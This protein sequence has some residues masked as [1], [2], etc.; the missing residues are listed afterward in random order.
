MEGIINAGSGVTIG[1]HV[2]KNEQAHVFSTTRTIN[3]QATSLGNSYNINSG[4]IALTSSSDSGVFYFKNDEFPVNG[5]SSFII[6]AIAIGI[7][8]AGTT[9]K[10]STIT[11]VR[12]PS[13]GTLISGASAVAMNQ[14]RNFGSPN[15]LNST[16]YAYKGVEGSTITN[17]NDIAIFFQS[18]GSRGY[19]TVDFELTKGSSI[20]VKLNTYTS[21]GTTNAYIAII[22]HRKDGNNE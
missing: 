13:T 19:Y 12:N 15:T 2:D 17:G 3:E 18:A 20:G 16:S 1:M 14:N 5:E 4:S 6:D 9:T 8:N 22:G 10:N 21:S 11:V 7:D